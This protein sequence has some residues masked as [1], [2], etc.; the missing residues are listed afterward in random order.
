MLKTWGDK[1]NRNRF[2]TEIK[3]GKVSLDFFRKQKL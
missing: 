2:P 1:Y 3:I